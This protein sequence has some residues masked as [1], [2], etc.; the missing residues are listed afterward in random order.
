M[1]CGADPTVANVTRSKVG[2]SEALRLPLSA[3]KP[4]NP[5]SGEEQHR[6]KKRSDAQFDLLR[7]SAKPKMLLFSSGFLFALASMCS[8]WLC[9]S[10]LAAVDARAV[11]VP[12]PF[13]D[14]LQI[15]A[16]PANNRTNSLRTRNVSRKHRH[17]K[18][19]K[20][21]SDEMRKLFF[22]QNA[23]KKTRPVI[24]GRA[25]DIRKR[26]SFCQ[27]SS[28]K[29]KILE[30]GCL[31]KIVLNNYCYGQCNS[32]YIPTYSDES[33]TAAEK[34]QQQQQTDG[35]YEEA[36]FKSCAFCKPRKFRYISVR[37]NC[38]SHSPPF[39]HK[40]VQIIEKCRCLS[41]ILQSV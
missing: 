11:Q 30:P 33:D 22:E 27:T 39:K 5:S 13:L 15:A 20:K 40:R 17:R 4:R 3:H 21:E 18:N 41:E 14:H 10:L 26:K 28:F 29:Q 34:N 36:A 23:D 19:I 6:A 32:F 31:P 37:L 1:L 9:S 24:V 8:S 2:C 12:D 25:S 16:D 7:S 35:N 38:P